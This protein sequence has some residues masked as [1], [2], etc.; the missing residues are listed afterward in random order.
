[1]QTVA[2][3][4][5]NN[6]HVVAHGQQYFLEV[7]GLYGLYLHVEDGYFRQSV[8]DFRHAVAENGAQFVEGYLGV[9]HHV[10]QQC[11]HHPHGAYAYV[12]DGDGRHL[13][14]M[15]NVRLARFASHV[16]MCLAGDG[17]ST[18]NGVLFFGRQFVDI[19]AEG[20]ELPVFLFNLLGFAYFVYF[21]H[22]GV[23]FG[24]VTG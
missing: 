24:Y 5:E 19:V 17:E 22:G 10:V 18:E 16:G 11:A 4:Q 21:V 2:E 15:E 14:R 7:F 1:M 3:F 9:L 13:Q 20:N 6:I 8:D 12:L 23:C